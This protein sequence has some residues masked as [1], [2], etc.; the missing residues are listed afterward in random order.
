MDDYFGW[1]FENSVPGLPEAA[2]REGLTPL[3]YMRK[4]G[5]FEI[6]SGAEAEFER[7]LSPEETLEATK[8]EA[9][10]VLYTRSAATPPKNIVPSPVA[11]SGE[12]GRPIGV[13]VDGEARFG[14]RTP[15]RR[16]EFF[17]STLADFGWP[18]LAIPTYIKSHV[19]PD[20]VDRGANEFVLLSTYRLPTLIHTRSGNAKWLL[21]ISHSNPTWIHTSDAERLGSPRATWCESKRRSATSWTGSG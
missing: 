19:H 16:L 1:M 6:R 12:R 15:S 5:A 21:E 2:T 17:S 10:G 13:L 9:T 4:Y 20:N 3:A 14:F 8:D 18:E 7:A 11:P